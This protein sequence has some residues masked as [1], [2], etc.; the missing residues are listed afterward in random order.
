MIAYLIFMASPFIV[1][2]IVELITGKKVTQDDR[3]KNIYLIVCGII[4]A[5]MIGMRNQ[6]N[7]SSDTATYCSLYEK[8]SSI[9]P[10]ELSSF[11]RNTDM[12]IGYLITTWLFSKIFVGGQWLLV[13]SGAFFSVSICHFVKN[14]CKNVVLALAVFNCL[15]LFNFMVQGLRQAIAMC[16]CLWAFELCKKRKLIGF[17]LVVI[18]AAFFHAS[19]IVFGMVYILGCMRL[20][21][22][23]L[24]WM[25]MG[26]CI[27]LALLPQLFS[28]M[29]FV[30][31]DDYNTTSGSDVG[32]WVAILIYV[33]I[34]AF[35]LIFRDSDDKNYPTYM[36]MLVAGGLCMVFRQSVN[37]ILER[38]GFY[39]SFSQMAVISN[40]VYGMKD[41]QIRAM[42]SMV[43]VVLCLGVAL[44]K[45]SYSTLVPYRFFWN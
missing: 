44:H 34:F 37:G 4:I 16:I 1:Y 43:V 39:F 17:L 28:L 7:G 5:L 42:V 38:I 14:N 18:L 8:M 33:C 9:K 20:D 2:L 35:G 6:H 26:T 22:R 3:T 21:M 45:A 19:A 29:N 12:E 32:G 25:G 41:K 13:F 23:S 30:M 24:I 15:G 27:V 31:N 40:A 36:F 10:G 11:I